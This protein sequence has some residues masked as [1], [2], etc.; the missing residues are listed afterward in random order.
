MIFEGIALDWPKKKLLEFIMPNN[1]CRMIDVGNG[2]GG[3]TNSIE[4]FRFS[5]SN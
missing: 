4:A 5:F 3:M 2:V 1:T